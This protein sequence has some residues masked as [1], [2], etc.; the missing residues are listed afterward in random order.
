MNNNN[1]CHLV[2]SFGFTSLLP[3]Y[4]K[5]SVFDRECKAQIQANLALEYGMKQGKG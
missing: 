4:Y 1:H 3:F 5:F 2:F